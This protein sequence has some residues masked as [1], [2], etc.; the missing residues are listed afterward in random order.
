M[1][2]QISIYIEYTYVCMCR[3]SCRNQIEAAKRTTTPHSNHLLP[4]H[5]QSLALLL[6]P[7]ALINFSARSKRVTSSLFLPGFCS[8]IFF[9]IYIYFFFCFHTN[10]CTARGP[11]IALIV[12]NK[13]PRSGQLGKGKKKKTTTV[14][15]ILRE[16]Q[17]EVERQRRSQLAS[18]QKGEIETEK[19]RQRDGSSK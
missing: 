7:F 16:L 17:E 9:Y 18:C 14:G 2:V 11:A 6:P 10:T 8:H 1:P 3:R 12:H 4:S 5:L 13:P 15:V 19:P